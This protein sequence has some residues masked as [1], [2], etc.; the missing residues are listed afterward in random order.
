MNK[1]LI[2]FLVFIFQCFLINAQSILPKNSDGVIEYS[3][4]VYLDSS[5]SKEAIFS[6]ARSWFSATF[7]DG[8]EVLQIQDKEA[9]ELVGKGNFSIPSS[10]F[11]YTAIGVGIVWFNVSIYSKN[12]R[13]K[14]SITN[15]I[16]EGGLNQIRDCGSLDNNKPSQ[17]SNSIFQE[18]K[19]KTHKKTLS[20][21][22]DLK[23]YIE[24]NVSK[25]QNDW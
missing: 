21:I 25:S 9:G 16:H 23:N 5:A 15:F 22:N 12:G 1:S 14:Y 18:V 10:R 7:K 11:G 4:V 6:A 19:E 17:C 8:S 2:L 3:E 13:Y 20:L 24:S